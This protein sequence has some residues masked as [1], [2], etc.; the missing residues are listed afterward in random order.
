M[1][2]NTGDLYVVATPIG[3]LADISERAKT[4]LESVDF[5]AAE[6]TRHTGRLLKHFDISTKLISLHDH[7]ERLKVSTL[8]DKLQNGKSVALVS[9][10][11]TPLIS[12]P[13]FF[14]VREVREAGIKVIPVPGACA[15]VTALSAS[16]LATT[17]L[18]LKVFYLP[19]PVPGAS[20][21]KTSSMNSEVW[22]FMNLHT[23]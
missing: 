7:N 3:N 16:G 22:F 23:E 13:G 1:T 2:S 5:I 4:V 21:W 11:G 17:G 6:D 10:A 14:L 9:D 18:F 15:M 19:K 8:I 12:D 20:K